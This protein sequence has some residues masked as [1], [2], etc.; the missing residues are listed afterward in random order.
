MGR[1]LRDQVEAFAALIESLP[2]DR[3]QPD[4]WGP[5]EILA[6][7]AYWHGRYV[8][9]LRAAL[10]GETVEL[11][12]ATFKEL[13]AGAVQDAAGLSIAE[14]V[15]RLRRAQAELDA[16]QADPRTA[17]QRVRLKAGATAWPWPELRRR[18]AG[19]VRG[20]AAAVRRSTSSSRA[21]RRLRSSRMRLRSVSAISIRRS[22]R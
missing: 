17:Q 18:V 12:A 9:L 4:A 7:L 13:N 5:R 22:D 6:H 15:D 16:L 21:S 19:H 2:P 1:D 20:H 3:L 8:A 11:P 14:L 10:A